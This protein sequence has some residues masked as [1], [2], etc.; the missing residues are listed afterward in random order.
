M[1]KTTLGLNIPEFIRDVLK[2]NIVDPTG[3]ERDWIFKSQVTTPIDKTD[4][5]PR[6]II[7]ITHMGTKSINMLGSKYVP[8]D[9]I[10]DIVIYTSGANALYNRDNLC[11][12]VRG[13]L[14][15]P[16]SADSS[17]TTL[18]QNYLL[19]RSISESVEDF[20]GAHSQII[21]SKRL[22]CNF[23]FWGG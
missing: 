21:R 11:D 5:L 15:N 3:E 23:R 7:D 4:A 12:S 14:F 9:I 20:F 6:I 16:N 10:A 22:T 8:R 13:V 17:G 1:T 19:C 18:K 2:N